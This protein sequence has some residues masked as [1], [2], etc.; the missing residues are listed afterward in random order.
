[1]AKRALVSVS[2]KTGVVEFCNSLVKNGYEIISTG[3]TYKKLLEAGIN[4]IEIDE[5]TKFPECFEGRVKTL[6]PYVHGGILHR[7]DKQ[8]HL[9]QAKELSVESIDLVCVNLYPFKETIEKT[10]DFDDIIENIDIGGPA[11]VRSA[12]KNFD[13]VIIVTNVEDYV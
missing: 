7:R 3:G 8:S 11:M 10:D 12:A 13:S 5:V 1:L 6:N 4:A 9:D 2:D